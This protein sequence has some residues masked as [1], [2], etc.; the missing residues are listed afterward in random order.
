MF[1]QAAIDPRDEFARVELGDER[2][3]HRL[4]LL[5]SALQDAPDRSFPSALACD[6]ELE[7][8]Y[9][10]FNNGR[11][12]LDRLIEPHV[13]ATAKRAELVKSVVV[14]HDTTEFRFEGRKQRAGLGRIAGDGQGF[15]GHFALVLNGE[16]RA[17]LGLGGILTYAREFRSRHKNETP[18]SQRDAMPPGESARWRELIDDVQR[19]MAHMVPVHVMDREADD[20]AVLSGLADDGVRFVVRLNAARRRRG[21]APDFGKLAV[22]IETMLELAPITTTREVR[23]SPRAGK[24]G[25]VSERIH[26]PREGRLAKLSISAKTVELL[27]PERSKRPNLRVAV[28]RVV[29]TAPPADEAPVE[30]MLVTTE[31]IETTEQVLRI[32][33]VYRARWT[34]EEYF[35]ALKTGCAIERRQLESLHALLAALG[36]FAPLAVRL[37]ALRSYARSAPDAPASRILTE[38]EL[39][40]L[41]TIGRIKLSE[42]P[43]AQDALHAVAALG[44]HLKRNGEPGWIVLARGFEKLDVAAQVVAAISDGAPRC[45]Q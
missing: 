43:T 4:G 32:V 28:I 18:P 5:V 9:R 21:S 23:L 24:R 38:N 3:K 25:G 14:V 42:T 10:F 1:K 12:T 33:D 16:D 11:V 44:G 36:M 27:P 35:K 20:F 26:P 7:A 40:A 30:W 8:A 41:R 6:A 39:I 17:P 45:D 13:A 15:F 31:P 34:I 37:L 29:E 2:L 22:P 19:R